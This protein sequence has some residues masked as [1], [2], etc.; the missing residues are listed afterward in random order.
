MTVQRVF[1]FVF[2][3]LETLFL[4]CSGVKGRA[5]QIHSVRGSDGGYH[6]HENAAVHLDSKSVDSMS[7][8]PQ[9]Y[10]GWNLSRISSV[11]Q[12]DAWRSRVATAVAERRIGDDDEVPVRVFVS[13]SEWMTRT[14]APSTLQPD[15]SFL[16]DDCDV[17][18]VVEFNDDQ[19]QSLSHLDWT[20]WATSSSVR[21]ADIIMQVDRPW[22][23][24]QL[25]QLR[26][27]YPSK[28]AVF[29]SWEPFEGPYRIGTILMER[30]FDW[31]ASFTFSGRNAAD[32]PSSYGGLD[33]RD[34]AVAAFYRKSEARRRKRTIRSAGHS[35][36]GR[37]WHVSTETQKEAASDASSDISN[38]HLSKIESER[39]KS[40]GKNEYH[41]AFCRG[42]KSPVF[43]AVSNC[44]EERRHL[45][46][47]FMEVL[48]VDSYGKCLQNSELSNDLLPG[49]AALGGKDRRKQ[50]ECMMSCYPF[51][52]SIE[53]THNE[54]DY[55]TEKIFEPLEH[56]SVIPIYL[57]PPN[58][59]EFL[60]HPSA[61]ILIRDFAEKK[62]D[63]GTDVVVDQETMRRVARYIASTS[64]NA[65]AMQQL[66]IWRT[67]LDDRDFGHDGGQKKISEE[68]DTISFQLRSWF[69]YR[70]FFCNL[71]TRFSSEKVGIVGYDDGEVRSSDFML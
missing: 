6:G 59:R 7:L 36:Q 10:A 4:F 22:N 16:I 29:A 25:Q 3:I 47:A 62:R 12:L 60:P 34:D 38:N 17:P 14:S 40:G 23:T 67:E 11:L 61:A 24:K 20:P 66:Q 26:A 51:V 39:S 33:H 43:M 65:T 70:R 1:S 8:R 44:M 2:F 68:H 42:A 57:G 71:C 32:V 5:T 9:A 45:L 50:K 27:L 15:G 13:F 55:A 54:L 49:C 28:R 35:I 56:D 46:T 58:E 19:E 18:C 53:S 37:G 41:K 48:P 52:L 31:L 21:A 69:S 30:N 63:N 64:R